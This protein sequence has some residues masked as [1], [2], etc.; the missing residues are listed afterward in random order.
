MNTIEIN[1]GD[2]LL[3]SRKSWLA[4]AIQWFQE[5][6][7]N[8]AGLFIKIYDEIFVC[9]AIERGIINRHTKMYKKLNI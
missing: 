6:E 2:V 9:E 1:S 8:H 5:N 3:V 7:W 4:K